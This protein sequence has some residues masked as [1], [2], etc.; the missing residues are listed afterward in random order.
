[1]IRW[2]PMSKV[3]SIEPEGMTRAWPI[4]PLISRKTR[5]T[6][7]QA[8]IS[9]RMVCLTVSFF[10]SDFTFLAFMFHRHRRGFRELADADTLT[11]FELHQVGRIIPR[12]ARSTEVATRVIDGLA[13][14]S[15]RNVPKRVRAEK[16][17][18]FFRRIR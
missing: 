8:N 16:T 1:M 2:S 6:Q 5:P 7:N 13:K 4:A 9:R 10:A 3:F 14:A 17:P 12:I 15:E 11:N 18:N